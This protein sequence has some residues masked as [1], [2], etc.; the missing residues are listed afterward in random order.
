MRAIFLAFLFLLAGEVWVPAPEYNYGRRWVEEH[1]P[2]DK[3]PQS[4]RLFVAYSNVASLI[5]PFR[6]GIT[7][8]EI[9]DQT[10]AS[11]KQ[12]RVLVL[13]SSD[14]LAPVW[15]GVVAPSGQPIFTVQPQDMIWFIDLPAAKPEAHTLANELSTRPSA[16][17]PST[18]LP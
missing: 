12:V 10:K 9:I 15:D 6:E 7:L 13:R 8:R 14:K 18:N 17:L 1:N 5:I 2:N 4:A 3:T 11:G 16:R